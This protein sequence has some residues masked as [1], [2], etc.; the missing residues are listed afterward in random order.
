MIEEWAGNV[1]GTVVAAFEK[2]TPSRA[3]LSM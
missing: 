1:N 2:R 3:S